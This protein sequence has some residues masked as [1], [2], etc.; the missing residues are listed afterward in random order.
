MSPAPRKKPAAKKPK[1]L[2]ATKDYSETVEGGGGR[3]VTV[4]TDADNVTVRWMCG[5]TRTFTPAELRESIDYMDTVREVDGGDI[6]LDHQDTNRR[7][8]AAVVRD[9]E[10]HADEQPTDNETYHL[11]WDAFKT[12]LEGAIS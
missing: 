4:S 12:A 7:R 10:F 1:K 9:G 5:T 6:W 3:Q 11:P 2:K 8:F